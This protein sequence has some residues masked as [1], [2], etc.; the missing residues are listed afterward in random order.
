MFTFALQI[1]AKLSEDK[2][3]SQQDKQRII[4]D[5]KLFLKPLQEKLHH[6]EQE[7]KDL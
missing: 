6:F 5:L 2:D 1:H 3:L 7:L 4:K